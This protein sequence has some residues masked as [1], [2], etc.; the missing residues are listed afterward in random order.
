MKT[1][2]ET[3]ERRL[4]SLASHVLR[5]CEAPAL[6]ACGT[7]K[8]GK[9]ILRKKTPTVLQSIAGKTARRTKAKETPLIPQEKKAK[10]K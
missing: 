4:F 7:L 5:V 6:R 8:L 1:E 3:G 2:S 9:T 10:A